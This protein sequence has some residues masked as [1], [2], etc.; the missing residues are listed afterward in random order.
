M[1][2]IYIVRQLLGKT[3][4]GFITNFQLNFVGFTICKSAEN[5]FNTN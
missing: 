1:I 5:N 2:L 4:L 3:F